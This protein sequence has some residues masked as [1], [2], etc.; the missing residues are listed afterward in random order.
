MFELTV[1]PAYG[2]TYQS[3]N[4]AWED[5]L[6]DLDFQIVSQGRDN[7]RYLNRNDA[8]KA[9]LACLFVRYGKQLEKSCSF[10]LIKGRV[11]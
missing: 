1:I 2:R 6:L 4:A 3:K 9:G 7:G 10:N 11:N 8:E 5:W